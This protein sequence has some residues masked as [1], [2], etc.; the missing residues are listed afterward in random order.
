MKSGKLD[1]LEHSGT[2]Q[3][4]NGIALPLCLYRES[5]EGC[6]RLREGVPDV[7]VYRYNPK[8]LCSKLNGYGE[9]AREV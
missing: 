9:M 1:F 3:V 7:K 5:Q 2:L 6:A 8:Y 4:C